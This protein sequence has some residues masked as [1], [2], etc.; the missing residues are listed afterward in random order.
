V[1]SA[2][3]PQI[4]LKSWPDWTR[5]ILLFLTLEVAVLSVEL[6]H[7]IKPQP[8]LT[9]V[10]AVAVLA[11]FVLASRRIPGW[12]SHVAALFVGAAVSLWQGFFLVPAQPMA[13]RFE[14]LLAALRSWQ[15]GGAASESAM[16]TFGVFLVVLT[17]L[18]G[19]VATWCLLRRG[20]AWVG[21]ALG[22]VIV[23]VNL[24]N[25]P[26]GLHIFLFFGGYFLASALLIAWNRLAGRLQPVGA[27]RRYGRRLLV[28]VG[29]SLLCLVVL[30]GAL[31]WVVPAP[32]VPGLQ[33]ALAARM[34]WKEDIEG[35]NLNVFAS[36]PSKQP[37]N[38]G[39]SLDKIEF[40]LAWHAS[41][42]I[43]FIV[44]S[45]R[46]SYWRVHVYDVYGAD[47]WSNSPVS[48]QILD[49]DTAWGDEA[50]PP[51]DLMT[52]TVTAA[53]K[54]D[55]LLMAGNFVASDSPVLVHVGAGDIVGVTIPR[56]LAPGESYSVASSFASPSA[57]DL[58]AV[59]AEYPP[60]ITASYL[61]LPADFP[62]DI[63]QLARRLTRRAQT[64][65]EKVRAIDDYL[66]RF[67]YATEV[68][69]PPEGTDS[70]EHF[71]FTGKS[72][73]CLYFASA[74]AVMLRSVDIPARLAVGYLPG[75]AG[76]AA[77]EYILRDKYYHAWVQAYFPGYGW[78]DVEA[79]PSGRGGSESQVASETPWV[80]PETIEQLSAWDPWQFLP[81]YLPPPESPQLLAEPQPAPES[82]FHA[83]P[84][85]FA[86]TLGRLLLI[87]IAGAILVAVALMPFLALRKAFFRWLW[88]VDR[89]DLPDAA[90]ARMVALAGMVNLGPRPQ[91]TPLEFAAE[92]GAAFP[93]EAGDVDHI[94]RV[95][96]NSR[97]GGKQSR[98]GL[99]EEA[100][101][102]KARCRVYSRF[103][104][105]LGI[106][107]TVFGKGRAFR[108]NRSRTIPQQT[109]SAA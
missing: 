46:P 12:L 105:R 95:Y 26:D 21:P 37:I 77:G 35:S 100:E 55:V 82:Q 98:L 67:D 63:S 27:V 76:S 93:Q 38:T 101:V 73:F 40:G 24:S 108:E 7:W 44:N 79:T 49:E 64:P 84:L 58:A 11:G 48:D 92:L 102:L 43:N 53:T 2:E 97:F 54:T 22:A 52:Y 9:L 18:I 62:D 10:L 83:G 16:I 75:E 94:A 70:I 106:L 23:L 39:A 107:G 88:H 31:A 72:G 99:F 33:T 60:G 20:N 109:P 78:V 104:G 69:A 59:R 36:V 50:V 103:L 45:P 15:A 87:I 71:L 96:A 91:Q 42:K 85:P 66:S 13:A 65:Y 47:G 14:G 80:S 68:T 8:S 5:V 34:L 6:A 41:E 19:Y 61:G 17:W 28:Y 89:G 3:R 32:R 30:A 56:L 81:P 90:Y 25:L 86:A 57:S 51:D 1:T 4:K 74:M 29:T